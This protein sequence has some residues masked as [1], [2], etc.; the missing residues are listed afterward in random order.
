M[1][2][3]S[4]FYIVLIMFL[5][6]VPAVA[7]PFAPYDPDAELQ[8][9]SEWPAIAENDAPNL[10][11]L[12]EAG[13]WFDDHFAFR[14][15]TIAL[16]SK[17][18]A[19]IFGTSTTDQVVVGSDGWL[20][21]GGTMADYQ[22][23]IQMTNRQIDVA[24][25]NLDLVNEFVNERGAKF[26]VAVAPNKNSLYN[27]YMPYYEMKGDGLSNLQ[28]FQQAISHTGIPAV[29]LYE[30]FLSQP[31]SLY[32]KTD[33]HWNTEGAL[34]AYNNMLD[35][36]SLDHNR[37]E[38]SEI[39]LNTSYIGDIEAMLYPVWQ[40]P[41]PSEIYEEAQQFVY[42]NDADSAEDSFILTRSTDDSANE[43]SLLMFRDSF[44][45]SLLPFFASD[46]KEAC[47]SRLVPYDLTQ[48]DA[49]NA[50]VVIIERAERHLSYFAT[51]APLMP[52]PVRDNVFIDQLR[53]DDS[54][55]YFDNPS[56]EI[57][58][59]GDFYKIS[60]LLDPTTSISSDSKILLS[61]DANGSESLYEAFLVD[62]GSTAQSGDNETGFVLYIDKNEFDPDDSIYKLILAFSA[63]R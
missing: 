12:S 15:Q 3:W 16:D 44:G 5:L 51:D 53:S 41:E 25:H 45:I 59:D 19:G 31:K 10:N 35:E 52:A 62:Q 21:Y 1:F 37:Y 18:Q 11:Y 20:Y 54:I 24:I 30:A 4:G 57:V 55:S 43:N 7:I 29:D 60:G 46:F 8:D 49:L 50:D 27:E 33:S 9:L 42:T 47:F 48:I 56:I 61:V 14:Q 40:T 28:R 58:E 39:T 63:D 17:I 13:E 2:K 26:L 36:I 23:T 38:N 6:V 32:M 22:R 34:F